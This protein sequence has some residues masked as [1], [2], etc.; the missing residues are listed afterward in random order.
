MKKK[1]ISW[2][3]EHIDGYERR[4]VGEREGEMDER[5]QCMAMDNK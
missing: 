2:I 5:C 3:R 4:I 1:K